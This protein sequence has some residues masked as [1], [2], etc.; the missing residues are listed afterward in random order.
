MLEEKYGLVACCLEWAFGNFRSAR[1]YNVL[2]MLRRLKEGAMDVGAGDLLDMCK[3]LKE[4]VAMHLVIIGKARI[5]IGIAG[6]LATD[7][8]PIPQ[9]PDEP[10][11][12][13]WNRDWEKRAPT[14]W[15]EQDGVPSKK[16]SGPP[17]W[18]DT[19][20]EESPDKEWRFHDEDEEHNPHWDHNPWNG[21]HP[22]KTPW[23]NIPIAPH[24]PVKKIS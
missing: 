9:K 5:A 2:L 4:P 6:A 22:W 8:N 19:T 15:N 18:F 21:P 11:P 23:E 3:S 16:G 7:P 10:L 12:P 17:R 1:D 20:D 13:G 24:P 14:G